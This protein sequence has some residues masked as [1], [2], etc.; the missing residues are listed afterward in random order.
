MCSVTTNQGLSEIPLRLFVDHMHLIYRL[1]FSNNVL[2][3]LP[4]D[5]YHHFPSLA[6]LTLAHNQLQALQP[7]IGKCG[8]LTFLDLSFNKLESLPDDFA[9]AMK[10]LQVLVLSGNPL[11]KLPEF[12]ISSTVLQEL[13]ANQ[14]GIE[15][16]PDAFPEHSALT[17]LH[18]GD[19]AIGRLPTSFSSLTQLADLDLMGMK[20]IESQDSKASVTS[21]AFSAFVNANPLLERIDKKVC[22]YS[23]CC[24]FGM[25]CSCVVWS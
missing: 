17:V 7:G 19:N 2:Q 9:E 12:I 8:S 5:F 18:L 20:W 21:S 24:Q 13:F 11:F 4:S 16:L 23:S 1:D 15:E 3:S 6:S 14:T 22:D 10:T 25:L